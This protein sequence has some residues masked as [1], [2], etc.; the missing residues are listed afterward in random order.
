MAQS[1]HSVPFSSFC[2]PRG[3]DELFLVSRDNELLANVLGKV[4]F[5]NQHT[6]RACRKTHG[7][8]ITVFLVLSVIVS[9]RGLNGLSMVS[10]RSGSS[11]QREII[12][13]NHH[14]VTNQGE[15]NLKR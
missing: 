11:I 10:E 12:A 13:M 2:S 15:S 1:D 9:G 14:L 4:N 8:K 6:P 3:A 7:S 5:S